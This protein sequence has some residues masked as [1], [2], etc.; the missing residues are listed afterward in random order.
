MNL[1]SILGKVGGTIIENV[2]PGG[3][4]IVDVVNEFLP[5]DKK[6][7]KSA[8]GQQ[9]QDAIATLPA[10]V[11]AQVLA[12]EF[13]VQIEEIRAHVDVTKAL[14]EVDKTGHSTRPAIAKGMAQIVGFTVIVMI[15]CLAV[16]IWRSDEQTIIRHW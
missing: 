3:S 4:L 11:Q 9:A 8:T 13:D 16:A 10:D 2:V 7:A 14:G 1:L 5:D 6:L 12:K 15:S